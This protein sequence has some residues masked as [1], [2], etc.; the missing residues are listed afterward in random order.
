MFHLEFHSGASDIYTLLTETEPLII[1]RCDKFIR[2]I[3]GRFDRQ[4]RS[5]PCCGH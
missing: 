4:T 5:L 3:V 1:S 2:A